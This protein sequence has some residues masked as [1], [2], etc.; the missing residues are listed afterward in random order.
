WRP[1]LAASLGDATTAAAAA[2]VADVV[3]RVQALLATDVDDQR[4][5]PL[6]V[7]RGAVRYPTA[8]LRAA[9]VPPVVRDAFGE[10]AFPDDDYDLTPAAFGDLDPSLQELGIVWGA[11][12]AHVVL[13]RRR[14]EG[15]R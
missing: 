14:A 9:G 1:G 5:N 8:V 4:A 15:R 11:A 2:A 12:K 10:R 3:P 7:V 13:A 6:A